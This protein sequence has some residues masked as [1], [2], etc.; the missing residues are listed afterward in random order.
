MFVVDSTLNLI[1]YRQCLRLLHTS[2][3]APKRTC[4]SAPF[5][6]TAPARAPS[7]TPGVPSAHGVPRPRD[8]A[9]LVEHVPPRAGPELMSAFTVKTEDVHAHPPPHGLGVNQES[10]PA[11]SARP[12]ALTLEDSGKCVGVRPHAAMARPREAEQRNVGAWRRTDVLQRN[13]SRA[14]GS[15]RRA[16]TAGRTQGRGGGGWRA[17]AGSRRGREM[18]RNEEVGVAQERRGRSC[19]RGGER[20]VLCSAKAGRG[21][22]RREAASIRHGRFKL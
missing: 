18:A 20:G 5:R 3:K 1:A 11:A 22:G 4:L 8:A 21:V 13:R 6:R 12:Q 15:G 9:R 16:K 17:A 7:P 14:A 10:G 2:I 19:T